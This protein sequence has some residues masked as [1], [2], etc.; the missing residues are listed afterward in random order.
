VETAK[1]FASEIAQELE[2]KGLKGEK[3]GVTAL[4]GT[5]LRALGEL[6]INTFDAQPLLNRSPIARAATL[7]P[8]E[9]R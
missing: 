4:D 9:M 2:A 1:V 3:I 5:S 6:G 8:V 7:W